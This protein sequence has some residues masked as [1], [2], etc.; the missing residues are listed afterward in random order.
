MNR[1]LQAVFLRSSWSSTG[2]RSRMQR[3]IVIAVK[4]CLDAIKGLAATEDARFGRIRPAQE[5]EMHVIA[6]IHQ[7][8]LI[9]KARSAAGCLLDPVDS[10]QPKR[11]LP[12]ASIRKPYDFVTKELLSGFDNGWRLRRSVH[13]DFKF[14]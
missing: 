6:L 1:T 4:P 3:G 11:L 2:T 14:G 7:A 10:S 13:V 9:T 5:A 8:E 12:S